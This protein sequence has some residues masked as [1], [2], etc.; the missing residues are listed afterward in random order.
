VRNSG[1]FFCGY[2]LKLEYEPTADMVLADIKNLKAHNE[3]VFCGYGEPTY[4]FDTLVEIAKKLKPFGI[5]LRLNTNGQAE[6]ILGR[7]VSKELAELIDTISISLNA[8]GAEKYQKMCQS[9]FGEK[10]FAAIIEFAKKCKNAGANVVFSVVD[11]LSD[12]ELS[13][14]KKIAEEYGADFRIRSLI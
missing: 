1:E 8:A 11:V 6:L 12:D 14:A 5:P 4:R 2:N 13:D 9:Q 3:I 7:D 10:A